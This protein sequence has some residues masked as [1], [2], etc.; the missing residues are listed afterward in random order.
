MSS[1]PGKT[2][3][4]LAATTAVCIALATGV[5]ELTREPVAQAARTAELERMREILPPDL[6]DNDPLA[7]VIQ[8]SA[9]I[10]LGSAEPLAVYRAYLDGEPSALVLQAVATDG[11]S[12]PI[13]LLV[14]VTADGV[15]LGVRVTRHQETPGL[16]D[17][18]D[19]RISPWILG[20]NQKSLSDPPAESWA[21]RRDGGEFDQFTAATITPRAV[22]KAVR[23]ALEYVNEH[24]T[25]LFAP[26]ADS[27]AENNQRKQHE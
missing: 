27:A 11:Y 21:V 20:F 3:A 18:I 17:G 8:I 7:D 10:G 13:D 22:V 4:V 12:G 25:Q 14:S 23:R 15:V 6:Y 2:A 5:A 1:R 26:A 19:T 16:G 24:S 9:P